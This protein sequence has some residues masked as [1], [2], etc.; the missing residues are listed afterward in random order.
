GIQMEDFGEFH[1]RVVAA[2]QHPLHRKARVTTADLARYSWVLYQHDQDTL[3]R[4]SRAL[5]AAGGEAP[6]IL[7]VT[8]SL[9]A[10]TQFLKC[11]PYLACLADAYVRTM[12]E[13]EVAIL[14]FRREIWSFPSGA[15]CHG[16]LRNFAPVAAL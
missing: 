4:L 6:D 1:L 8:T 2:R 3:D 16:S 5:R 13:P 7:V 14:P 9:H 10:V 15:L 11:G 12:A